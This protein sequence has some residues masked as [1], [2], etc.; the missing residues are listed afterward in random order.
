METNDGDDRVESLWVRIKGKANKTGFLIRIC[1]R[2]PN[3]DEE[4]RKTLY[5]QVGEVLRSIPLI[6]IADLKFPDICSIYNTAQ[7]E[8]SRRFLECVGDKFLTQLVKEPTRGSKILDLLFVNKEGLV[9]N[10]K[11]GGHLGR[12]NQEMLDFSIL[13]EPRRGVNRT[14]TLDFWRANLSLLRTMV[15]RVPWEVAL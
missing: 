13:V 12:S 9:G 10:M 1:Y 2:Q 15:E 11:F 4:V 7:R 8:Q 5:R 3:Q 14:A 6:L